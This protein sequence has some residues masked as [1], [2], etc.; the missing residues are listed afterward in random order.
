MESKEELNRIRS[1]QTEWEKENA[2]E[3]QKERKKEFFTHS[4]FPAKRIY[5]PVDLEEKGFDYLKDLGFPGD[6]PYTRGVN[7][8]MYR[9][10]IWGMAK[11]TGFPTPE[12]SNKFWRS[13]VAAGQNILSIAYDLPTQLGYDPDHPL[14]E[15]EVGRVGISMC[16]LRDWETA[17]SGIDLSKV[18]VNQVMNAAGAVG[19]ASHIAMAEKQG[20]DLA[21]LRGTCQNDIIKEYTARGN[22]VYPPKH[23]LRLVCDALHY[24]GERMPSYRP[25]E[26]CGQH[27]GEK[28]ATPLHEAAHCLANAFTY[29]QSAVDRGVDID[30]VAPGLNFF[31]GIRH[32]GFFEEI[33]KHRAIRRVYARVLKEKFGAKN[34]RSLI[35]RLVP[36][37][38]GIELHREQYLNN[39]ARIAIC[40]VEASL[41]GV[42]AMALASYDEQFGIPTVEANINTIRCQQ[43]VAYE[44]GIPDVVDPLAGSYF[45]E[46]LT[47]EFEEGIMKELA[48]VERIGGVLKG[49]EQGYFQRKYAEDAY[50]WQKAFE[51]G[52]MMRVG[53]NCFREEEES[54]PVRVYRCDPNI[55]ERRVAEVKELRRS[56]DNGRVKQALEEIKKRAS[57]DSGV[58]NNLMPP[59][60]EAVK[61]YATTGEICDVL[62]GVWGEYEEHQII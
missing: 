62:R 21:R 38:G 14:A 50:R 59:I 3:F 44:T 46:W 5:T 33:A 53:V 55:E 41:S 11:Y 32:T 1:A 10:F 39:I 40:A 61:A 6:Y 9:R 58:D 7:P 25:L 28:G 24:C 42:Q 48:N 54:R 45:V 27:L 8:S 35:C 4:G 13:Q 19:I 34:P 31:T 26:V 12:E 17:L 30:T 20:V 43:I 57:A 47:S 29:L 52:E 18:L 16:S 2:A 36:A 49:I 37:Q 60:I 56:R 51:K 23:A 15:G 22:Y